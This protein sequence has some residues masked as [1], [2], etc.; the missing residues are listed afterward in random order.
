[1][2]MVQVE[3]YQLYNGADTTDEVGGM[4]GLSS[5]GGYR[6]AMDDH[7]IAPTTKTSTISHSH[8]DSEI[9][10]Y[11]SRDYHQQQRHQ[12]DQIRVE[13]ETVCRFLNH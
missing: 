4:N 5:G 10:K 8:T 11:S 9:P 13:H 12:S 7:A 2:Q 1:M 6:G 3:L